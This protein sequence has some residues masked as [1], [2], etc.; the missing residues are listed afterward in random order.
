MPNFFD[1]TFDGLVENLTQKASTEYLIN[2]KYPSIESL[3]FS[4]L[5]PEVLE[6]LRMAKTG[7]FG[8]RTKKKLIAGIEAGRTDYVEVLAIAKNKKWLD[9]GPER[10]PDNW[11]YFYRVA[12]LD[13]TVQR[14]DIPAMGDRCANDDVFP[15]KTGCAEIVDPDGYPH[16]LILHYYLSENPF[17]VILSKE[18]F[19]HLE[20]FVKCAGTYYHRLH[21]GLGYL[22]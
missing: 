6:E 12:A 22:W 5:P 8:G 15:G 1:E 20:T 3:S 16:M 13:G 11:N 18:Q 10:D 17:Y 4:P 9:L 21:D 7:L 19:E 2:Q 14:E